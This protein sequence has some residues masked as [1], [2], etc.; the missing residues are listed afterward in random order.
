[1][2]GQCP[3]QQGTTTAGL[4]MGGSHHCP[5]VSQ[6]GKV[7]ETSGQRLIW[8]GSRLVMQ[9]GLGSTWLAWD[10]EGPRWGWA[11]PACTSA[12]LGD[13]RHEWGWFVSRNCIFIAS[14]LEA[15]LR[16]IVCQWNYQWKC[17]VNRKNMDLIFLWCL[18]VSQVLYD[19]KAETKSLKS[20]RGLKQ[21]L[22][23]FH[24]P[25]LVLRCQHR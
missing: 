12:T 10:G 24:M 3:H 19:I 14:P 25:V 13:I 15:S 11:G 21:W 6:R 23:F 16:P 20:D 17:L 1:M 4:R 5:A 7:S 8:A 22:F 18:G 9:H 2:A